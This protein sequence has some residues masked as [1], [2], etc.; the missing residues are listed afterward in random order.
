MISKY[1]Y[2]KI[3]E[4][5]RGSEEVIAGR[6]IYIEKVAIEIELFVLIN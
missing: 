2:T 3:V 1:F 6:Y 5:V 4:V